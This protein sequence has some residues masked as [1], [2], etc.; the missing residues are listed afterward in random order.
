MVGVLVIKQLVYRC[1]T[2]NEA[3]CKARLRDRGSAT[4]VRSVLSAILG[5]VSLA[6][7]D[8]VSGWE[9][10]SIQSGNNNLILSS[11]RS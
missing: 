8:A 2:S 10:A 6:T 5:E 1:I 9:A 11:F 4:S 7:R 3:S